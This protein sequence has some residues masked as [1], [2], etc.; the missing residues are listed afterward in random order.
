MMKKN[1]KRKNS[2]MKKLIPAAG[3]LAL[4]ASMLATSTYAWFTMNKEVSV[5]GMT[6]KTK[7]GSNL[8]VTGDNVEANYNSGLVQT[9]AALLEPVSTVS[10]VDGSFFYTVNAKANGDAADD[11]Y[12]PY[13]ENTALTSNSAVDLIN[14]STWTYSS[15]GAGKTGYDTQ[16][17]N[18]YTIGTASANPDAA[19]KNAYGYVDYVFYI[20]ATSDTDNQ[21]LRMTEC[22][23]IRNNA[24]ITDPTDPANDVTDDDLA[25]RVA[26]F[27][28]NITSDHP[29]DGDVS[30]DVTASSDSPKVILTRTGATN[31]IQN[32]AVSSQNSAPTAMSLNYNT[33]A[34]S[35]AYID[36][37]ASA[38]STSY[39][40]IV[41]RV[42]LEGEDTS[43][44]SSTYA[45]LTNEYELGLQFELINSDETDVTKASVTSI[46]S[47]INND[48]GAIMA[49][50]QNN[51]NNNDEP[52]EG[53]G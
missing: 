42:W 13:N 16:F 48:T 6:M 31:H 27:A 11:V 51:S 52:N 28:E 17:N 9:R 14:T 12:L 22:N 5:T 39:Y 41:A 23:L 44:K 33:W 35:K 53:N 4:S 49:P 20:K 29:G 38:G 2:T 1:E 3:M 26:I 25:W 21:Q 50:A 36:Q 19:Y 43:C 45:L 7:V 32:Y 46:G 37:I 8:L 40:K 18:K 15:S 10:G 34:D 47:A 30:T 24:V